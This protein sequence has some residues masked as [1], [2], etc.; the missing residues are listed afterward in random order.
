M[1]LP[2]SEEDLDQFEQLL[3]DGLMEQGDEPIILGVDQLHGFMTALHCCPQ[4]I[5]PSEFAAV[6]FA[7]RRWHD[8]VQAER[9]YMLLMR[10][11]NDISRELMSGVYEPLLMERQA[12]DGEMVVIVSDWARG[13]LDGIAL[14]PDAWAEVHDEARDTLLAPIIA[15]ADD[16]GRDRIPDLG[17]VVTRLFRHLRFPAAAPMRR[18]AEK[19][20][21]NDPCHCG[22]GRKFKHCHG[23]PTLH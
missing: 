1:D 8:M 17:E 5:M 7:G 2:L 3:F 15:L 10:M 14:R 18:S 20:R 16:E 21:R 19:V 4:M 9:A 11:N 6:A 12:D 13:F 22:S 23:G